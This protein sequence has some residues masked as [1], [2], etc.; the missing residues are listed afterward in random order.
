M[1]F[2]IPQEGEF[3][4]LEILEDKFRLKLNSMERFISICKHNLCPRYFT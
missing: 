3:S 1:K 4:L 2:N